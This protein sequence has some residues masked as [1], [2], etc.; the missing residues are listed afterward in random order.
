MQRR[1]RLDEDGIDRSEAIATG[2]TP[3]ESL[4][5]LRELMVE[6]LPNLRSNAPVRLEHQ[7]A[8]TPT[9]SCTGLGR[10]PPA[11]ADF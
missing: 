10:Y 5:L 9:G 8:R 4:A 1:V 3:D 7:P 6:R 11:E 2:V